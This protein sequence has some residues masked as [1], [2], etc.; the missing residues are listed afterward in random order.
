MKYQIERDLGNPIKNWLDERSGFC[1]EEVQQLYI[2]K[3]RDVKTYQDTPEE[4]EI[5]MDDEW[6]VYLQR[7]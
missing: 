5:D 2:F 6:S 7:W 1:W 3:I 4:L